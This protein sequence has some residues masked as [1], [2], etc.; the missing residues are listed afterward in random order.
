VQRDN[1]AGFEYRTEVAD[2]L[3]AVK[4]KEGSVAAWKKLQPA[5]AF[6]DEKKSDAKT[7]YISVSTKGEAA[8]IVAA[9]PGVN[10]VLIDIA[11]PSAYKT[12]AF[13]SD[14]D[15]DVDN[16]LRFLDEAQA[17]A[18]YWA[19]P[20]AERGYLLNSRGDRA[21]ALAAYRRAL[22]LAEAHP[23]SRYVK[24]MA[25]RGIGWT[26]VE[27]GDIAGAKSAYEASL[28]AEPGDAL[29][30]DELAYI[31]G[32]PKNGA[33]S[34]GI[35]PFST[36]IGQGAPLKDADQVIRFTRLLENDPFDEQ[37][38]AMRQWLI[39]W[40]TDSADV[41]VMVCDVLGPIPAKKVPYGSELLVQSMFGNAAYQIL[42]P[43]RT[44]DQLDMQLAGIQST[45]KAYSAIAKHDPSARIPYFDDLLRH[46]KE[47]T[48]RDF[49][50]PIVATK[51]S[52]KAAVE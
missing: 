3:L 23:S 31:A 10:I 9:R 41:S 47:G 7:S 35:P 29:A 14:R 51:C 43:V 19:E 5:L 34:A 21:N 45:L 30:K 50:T 39:A 24:G 37:A 27:T 52:S 8:Q 32:L 6:C 1:F 13:L 15:G 11:C 38:A 25:L 17:I 46:E 48:L 12:A 26:L 28:L 22:E 33:V 36:V 40:M 2:A 18:P 16:A 4:N 49:L 42:H 44:G 20:Y